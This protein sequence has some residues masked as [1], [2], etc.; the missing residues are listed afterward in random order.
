MRWSYVGC[1]WAALDIWLPLPISELSRPLKKPKPA[2][3]RH[4][5]S[6]RQHGK[7]WRGWEE[8]VCGTPSLC[9]P[10]PCFHPMCLTLT[11]LLYVYLQKLLHSLLMKRSLC[12]SLT[13]RTGDWTTVTSWADRDLSGE[14]LV[15]SWRSPANVSGNHHSVRY[16]QTQPE[17][18]KISRSFL[19]R[20]PGGGLMIQKI[21]NSHILSM[22]RYFNFK[23]SY[24]IS[25][26]AFSIS[27][28]LCSWVLR[29]VEVSFQL[30]LSFCISGSVF[31]PCP[32]FRPGSFEQKSIRGTT[33]DSVWSCQR[34]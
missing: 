28:D 25:L 16:P 2:W 13:P 6:L 24:W 18:V 4:V 15:S 12:W 3:L 8:L 33:Q 26:R 7:N 30:S 1:C 27:I 9:S 20:F 17:A 31:L 11:Y 19:T 21:K 34:D 10:F 22:K 32:Y 29:V 14:S 5:S 23:C